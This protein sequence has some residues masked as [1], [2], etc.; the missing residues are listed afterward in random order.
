MGQSSSVAVKN[1]GKKLDFDRRSRCQIQASLF[2]DRI[3][4]VWSRWW[5]S[6]DMLE[7]SAGESDSQGK[8][9]LT[10]ATWLLLMP[11][12]WHVSPITSPNLHRDMS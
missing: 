12:F 5:K 1:T 7:A 3:G 11:S 8:L 10:A 9:H 6:R 2:E 4:L